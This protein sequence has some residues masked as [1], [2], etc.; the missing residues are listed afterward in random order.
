MSLKYLGDSLDIHGGGQDLVFPHHENEIAQSESFTGKKPFVK[1]WLHNGLVQLGKE[2]MSKSLGNLITIRE[3]LDKYSADAI[4]IF[5]LSSYYRSPLTYSEE[6][7]EAAEKG[8][9]R[10]RQAAQVED[11]ETE[12]LEGGMVTGQLDPQRCEEYRGKFI[13]AMDDDFGTPR[14]LAALYDLAR[15]I[16]LL[17]DA[18]KSVVQ[19]KQALLELAGVLGLTLEKEKQVDWL[20][21]PDEPDKEEID[22]AKKRGETLRNLLDKIERVAKD[23][24]RDI[25][26]VR[27]EINLV[28][29][30]RES[31][32][33]ERQFKL[34][35]EIRN[36][37]I[38]CG[39]TLEDT[40][41]GT[42]WKIKRSG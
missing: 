6:A 18:G 39:F 26:E 22:I 30:V 40:P 37:L 20:V 36:R 12:V 41:K 42:V 3:A 23:P 21:C 1:Y 17:S 4:R 9:E 34:A 31:L 16:N 38:T 27:N 32:R 15:E 24:N 29:A 8:V 10:L 19:G 5:V 35:D 33:K 2:K 7:L 14:A 28:R 13:E 11:W 25:E